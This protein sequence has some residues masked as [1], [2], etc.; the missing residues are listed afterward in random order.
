MAKLIDVTPSGLRAFPTFAFPFSKPPSIWAPERSV[1]QL[2]HGRR[3]LM[4]V[5]CHLERRLTGPINSYDPAS[6]SA[7]R[8]AA[9]PRAIQRMSDYFLFR[10]S[11]SRTI[12]ATLYAFS[13]FL[14]WIDNNEHNRRFEP[15]LSDPDSALEA[16]EL[17]YRHLK[18]KIQASAIGR[19]TGAQAAYTTLQVLSTIHN[20][21]YAEEIEHISSDKRKPTRAPKSEDVAHFLSTLTAIFDSVLRILQSSTSVC[22]DGAWCLSISTDDEREMVEL[23]EGYSRARLIDL[24]AMSYV[25]MVICD[26]GVNL[27]QIQSYVEPEDLSE[28]LIEPDRVSL[29]QKIVKLRAGG[30]IVPVTMSAVTFTRLQHFINIRHQLIELLG[31]DDIIPFFYGC[32]YKTVIGRSR[33]TRLRIG[34]MEPEAI[35]PIGDQFLHQLRK[36]V[37]AAG[38]ELPKVTLRQLRAHK[39]QHLVRHYGLKVA[40]DA[41]GHTIA[42][43]VKAYCA[44]QE[45]VQANDIG[46]FMSSLH[47][48]V[49]L[50]NHEQFNRLVPVPVGGCVSHGNPIPSDPAPLFEP[51]CLKTEGCFFCENF[52]IHADEEDLRKLLSCRS[53]LQKIA[54]LQG[55]S[56]HSDGVYEAVLD[57]IEFLSCE[58]QRILKPETFERIEA[59]TVA[60]SLT[61]YWSIKTQQ[62]GLLGLIAIKST[63]DQ[64]I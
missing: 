36:K 64:T 12:S 44:A 31:C 48:T 28:Q 37:A 39:Q 54:H 58:L 59:E 56:A 61:R 2:A 10:N 60:G 27:A 63:N 4:F 45:G 29:T 8:V 22:S 46:R 9:L 51:N 6:L 3:V 25:G 5:W 35:K 24:A 34:S 43:A 62:L 49:V 57:R 14:A 38:A 13:Q 16:L 41:M 30:K 23:P 55:E 33:K 15:V 19:T 18:W 20:R 17:Y 53:V 26:S 47:K 40:A 32:D 11:S 21:Q 42:T 50:R 1:L 7:M 52:R